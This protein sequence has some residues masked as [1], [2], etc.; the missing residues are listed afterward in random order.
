MF[1]EQFLSYRKP[2]HPGREVWLTIIMD[3]WKA[4]GGTSTGDVLLFSH[5]HT[6]KDKNSFN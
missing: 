1:N 3:S 5:P 6:F 2:D 4:E